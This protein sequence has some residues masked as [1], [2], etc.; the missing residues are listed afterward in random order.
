[1][2]QLPT[3]ASSSVAPVRAPPNSLRCVSARTSSTSATNIRWSFVTYTTRVDGVA[4]G[5]H[6][7]GSR[8]ATATAALASAVVTA[9]PSALETCVANDVTADATTTDPI[10][11]VP[12][13]SKDTSTPAPGAAPN[14]STYRSPTSKP[15]ASTIL[16]DA[17]SFTVGTPNAARRASANG[18]PPALAVSATSTTYVSD[19][20][21]RVTANTAPFALVN[22]PTAGATRIVFADASSSSP[23]KGTMVISHVSS[24]SVP[25]TTYTKCV[26]RIHAKNSTVAPRSSST[27]NLG[28]DGIS[29]SVHRDHVAARSLSAKSSAARSQSVPCSHSTDSIEPVEHSATTRSPRSAY[30]G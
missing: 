19:G 15:L 11:R 14:A 1:M 16:N 12:R 8:A 13:A 2:S 25:R 24:S 27:R 23:S 6:D 4:S 26:S 7:V 10:L 22:A 3:C 5:V 18:S 20:T 17:S 28:V 9:H 30:D 29:L 21:R